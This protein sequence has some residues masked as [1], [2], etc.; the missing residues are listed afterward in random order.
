MATV[1]IADGPLLCG[2]NVAIKWSIKHGTSLSAGGDGRRCH[3]CSW[4]TWQLMRRSVRPGSISRCAPV[5]RWRRSTDRRSPRERDT[6]PGRVRPWGSATRTYC[7]ARRW[8]GTEHTTAAWDDEHHS[9]I[10]P[11][12]TA[13]PAAAAGE[14]EP[15]H[16][17]VQ[18]I[19]H[20]IYKQEVKVIWQKAP[21][22]GPIP[23]LAVTPG[24]RKLYHWISG[25]GFPIS[26]P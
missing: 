20:K 8:Y 10:Q 7:A 25:V 6:W 13:L 1:P 19:N 18:S 21:H 2:F 22:G 26:V 16:Q 15:E 4:A 17:R 12:S 5:C 3:G 24:G 14:P 11:A 23:R 9:A